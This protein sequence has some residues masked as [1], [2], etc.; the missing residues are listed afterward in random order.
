MNF[1]CFPT[2]LLKHIF[3]K[4]KNKKQKETLQYLGH[5]TNH[6]SNNSLPLQQYRKWGKNSK[7]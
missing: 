6:C 5:A 4:G 1:C 7:H 3:S 2:M